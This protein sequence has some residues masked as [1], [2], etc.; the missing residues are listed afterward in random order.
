MTNPLLWVGLLAIVV[1]MVVPLLIALR[2]DARMKAYRDVDSARA[3][4]VGS[5]LVALETMTDAAERRAQADATHTTSAL[6][7]I[8]G[9]VNSQMT[10]VMQEA[11]DARRGQLV[12]MVEIV[13]LKKADGREPSK[14]AL[15]HIESARSKIQE[16]EQA[17]ADRL[18]QAGQP[19]PRSGV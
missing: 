8:H 1:A 14:E 11:L 16:L 15:A 17:I 9:L 18:S 4:V 6:E 7:V 3:D 5:K 13:D 19:A 10:T 2:I 12:T